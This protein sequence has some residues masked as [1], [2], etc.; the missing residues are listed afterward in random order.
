MAEPRHVS[1]LSGHGSPE[2]GSPARMELNQ[3]V[4]LTSTKHR[5]ARSFKERNFLVQGVPPMPSSSRITVR[6]LYR[7][8]GH[9]RTPTAWRLS[10]NTPDYSLNPTCLFS[11][12]RVPATDNPVRSEISAAWP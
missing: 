7:N 11:D 5:S 8:D 1:V 12:T 2:P 6:G 3:P 4:L 9:T 10:D